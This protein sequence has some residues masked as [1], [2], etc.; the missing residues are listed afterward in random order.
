MTTISITPDPALAELRADEAEFVATARS[1]GTI[2]S[3]HVAEDRS[4]VWL[5]AA[6]PDAEHVRSFIS[7]F[8]YAPW[9]TIDSIVDV[10]A[11]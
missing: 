10:F 8:P 11:P 3:I 7:Q 2:T 1:E 5:T 4:T 6:L 9:F